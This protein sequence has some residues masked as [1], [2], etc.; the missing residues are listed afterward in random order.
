MCVLVNVGHVTVCMYVWGDA[1]ECGC[2][3]EIV[4]EV[5]A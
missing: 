3:C 5:R 4:R 1:C 2:V